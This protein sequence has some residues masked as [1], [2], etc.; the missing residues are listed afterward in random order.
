[1]AICG[2]PI[3]LTSGRKVDCRQ[4]MN[5][6]IN[7][8]RSWVGRLSLETNYTPGQHSFVTLTYADEHL[9]PRASLLKFD[10][11]R[12]YDRIRKRSG[13]GAVRFFGVGEYNGEGQRTYNPH[14]HIF[15]FGVD[16]LEWR[17]RIKECWNHGN[18]DVGFVG[19]GSIDYVAN[20]SCS[21]LTG[22]SAEEYLQGRQKEFV[23]MSKNPPIGYPG[24]L[25]IASML[26]KRE[27]AVAL[28]AQGD[29]PH[30]YRVN[31]HVYPLSDYWLK[32]LRGVMGVEKPTY[33]P[34]E[35]EL[36]ET[37]K[38]RQQ[39]ARQASKRFAREKQK[40]RERK[41]RTTASAPGL[42]QKGGTEKAAQAQSDACGISNASPESKSSR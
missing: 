15:L 14:Y 29:V 36:Y 31:G 37:Q 3:T 6:R 7:A 17:D 28:A 9:P 1:M 27:G 23:V 2:Y 22:A 18:I 5:C 13:I 12:F 21:K 19:P 35:L 40:S 32:W 38:D 16:P 20:Y 8:K 11:R 34:W 4:C 39:A 25:K 30:S 24:M 26:H 42:G 33:S 41:L 10:L